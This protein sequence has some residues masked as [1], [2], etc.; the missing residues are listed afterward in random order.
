MLNLFY[1]VCF[2]FYDSTLDRAYFQSV[3]FLFIAVGNAP[4]FMKTSRSHLRAMV[5]CNTAFRV[6]TYQSGGRGFESCGIQGFFSSSSSFPFQI[7]FIIK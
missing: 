4:N 3:V 2:V 6:P 7:S 5:G 1:A